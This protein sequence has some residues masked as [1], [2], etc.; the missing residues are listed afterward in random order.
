MDIEIYEVIITEISRMG[1]WGSDWSVQ[2]ISGAHEKDG[3][4]RSVSQATPSISHPS[5]SASDDFLTS[6]S[7]LTHCRCLLACL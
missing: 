4:A 2:R 6:A 3:S 7:A 5:Q 1:N